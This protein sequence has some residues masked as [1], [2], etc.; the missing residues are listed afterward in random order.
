MVLTK[1]TEY[2]DEDKRRLKREAEIQS[3]RLSAMG[4]NLSEHRELE[5][6]P[7]DDPDVESCKMTKNGT[8]HLTEDV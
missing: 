2:L 4:E 1:V 8:A 6:L 3:R 7:D 5:F